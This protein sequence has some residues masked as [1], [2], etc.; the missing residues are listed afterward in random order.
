MLGDILSEMRAQIGERLRNPLLGAFTAG[1]FV[2]N[3]RLVAVLLLSDQPIEER[4]VYI[5]ENYINMIDQ[6]AIPL[7]FAIGYAI[8][9]PWINWVI[10]RLQE[11]AITL[12]KTHKLRVDTDYLLASVELATAQAALN[13]ILAKDETIK[14]QQ[15][16]LS[17]AKK[18]FATDS[19]SAQT[20]IA[21]TE[22]ELER[23]V[24]EKPADQDVATKQAISKLRSEL[25][26]SQ[27]ENRKAKARARAELD[28]RESKIEELLKQYGEIGLSDLGDVD[29]EE[30]LLDR[31]YRL[32]HN[33]GVGP[34]RSKLILFGA[35]GK[36]IEG[37][38]H[39]EHSWRIHDGKLELLQS[40][41]KVHSRFIYN[42]ASR[43]F[44][45]TAGDSD[46]RSA[47]GQFIIPE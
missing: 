7:A 6:L 45:H 29:I 38:N 30:L 39:N 41:D 36:I 46:T 32:F 20:K 17:D 25:E 27:Q 9:I 34:E 1:W 8:C 11:R 2:V 43:I 24:R 33:P 16:E 21:K 23:L 22:A 42:P 18:Q 35:N 13:R 37:G 47:R 10:Q 40:N 3:W 14:R 12:R 28:D 5:G 31:K 44:I 15:E 26:V 19:D 4:I